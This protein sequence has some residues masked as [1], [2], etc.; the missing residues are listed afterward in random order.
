MSKIND[1]GPAFPLPVSTDGSAAC[2]NQHGG[3]SVRQWYAGQALAGFTA[4]VDN[5]ACRP[6]E[7]EQKLKEW[8]ASDAAYCFSLADAMIAHEAAEREAK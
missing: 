8:A 1:G 2:W 5:R 3:L 4:Q 7:H 6:D